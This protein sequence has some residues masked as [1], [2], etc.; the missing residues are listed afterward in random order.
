MYE[1]ILSQVRL[2]SDLSSRELQVLSANCREREYPAGATL[3]RQGETGVGLFIITAGNVSVTQQSPEGDVRD[4]GTF[5]RGEVIGEM[6][7]LDDLPRTATVTAA[8]PTRALVIPVWDFRAAL[9]EAPE[10]AIKLLAV[11]SRR[12]RQ[13]EMSEATRH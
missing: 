10:I 6:S 3:M 2:F 7:L 1:D 12:L 8:E 4:L 13:H 11:M 9:R 5:G